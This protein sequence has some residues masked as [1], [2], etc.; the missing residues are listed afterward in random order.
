MK[1]VY[2]FN[3]AGEP[4]NEIA[5]T[6]VGATTTGFFI[7]TP[8]FDCAAHAGVL[9]IPNPGHLRVEQ[10]DFEGHPLGA[11]GKPGAREEEFPGCSNPTHL[12]LLP[13]GRIVVSQKGQPCL[14]LFDP[15]GVYLRTLGASLFAASTHGID[16]AASSKVKVYAVDPDSCRVHSFDL[17]PEDSL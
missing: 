13:D 14:K 15:K 7:P 9:Q 8:Y 2:R 1:A 17:G 16:L 3:R 11:W 12:A 5:S 4:L 6:A 10:Y